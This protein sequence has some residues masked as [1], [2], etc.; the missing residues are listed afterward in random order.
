MQTVE[1][2][3]SKSPS[4]FLSDSKKPKLLDFFSA[5]QNTAPPA[6]IFTEFESEIE[7]YL[8]SPTIVNDNPILYWTNS[9]SILKTMAL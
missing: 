3:K 8:K 9:N 4:S 7:N 1:T 2:T 5:I 6:V